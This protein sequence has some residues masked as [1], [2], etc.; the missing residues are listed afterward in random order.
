MALF[1]L[2]L[3]RGEAAAAVWA[4]VE[5]LRH[6]LLKRAAAEAEVLDGPGQ[7]A[8]GGRE[9]KQLADDLELLSAVAVHV[10]GPRLDLADHLAVGP[11]A[12][13]VL[14]ALAHERGNIPA[15]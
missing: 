1:F 3:D 14:L 6:E 13:A 12:E 10:D 7:V 11:G 5:V 2:A 9:R 8:R 15:A 4:V